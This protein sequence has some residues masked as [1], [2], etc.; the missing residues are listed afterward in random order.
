LELAEGLFEPSARNVVAEEP[1]QP[2]ISGQGTTCQPAF[3][4]LSYVWGDPG[5]TVPIGVDGCELFV[6][7]NLESF[8]RRLRSVDETRILWADAICIDQ[9]N[10]AERSSQVNLMADIYRS[11][12]KVLIW[13]GE[14]D[15]HTEIAFATVKRLA[16]WRVLQDEETLAELVA[17]DENFARPDIIA[18]LKCEFTDLTME[19]VISMEST[20]YE[21]SWW[22]RIWTVQEAVIP[23][24]ATII[25]GSFIIPWS[26]GYHL[27]LSFIER[28]GR[29]MTSP[30]SKLAVAQLAQ[31]ALTLWTTLQGMKSLEDDRRGIHQVLHM[32]TGSALHP[33]R[34]TDPRDLLYGILSLVDMKTLRITPDYSKSIGVVFTELTRALIRDTQVLSTICVRALPEWKGKRAPFSWLGQEEAIPS[35]VPDYCCIRY[36]SIVKDAPRDYPTSEIFKADGRR[37]INV[38]VTLGE[39]GNILQLQRIRWDV[40][41]YALRMYPADGSNST[42]ET[43]SAIAQ[44]WKKML[45][46][47]IYPT[48]EDMAAVFYR[49]L[50]R[51]IQLHNGKME[52][53]D[54]SITAKHKR[55][56]KEWYNESPPS[57]ERYRIKLDEASRRRVYSE[58]E[59]SDDLEEGFKQSMLDVFIEEGATFILTKKGYIG[60]VDGVAKTED[61]VC[62]AYGSCVPLILRPA[63]QNFQGKFAPIF[64]S[65][66]HTLVGAAY[67]HGIMDGEVTQS[68]TA[69]DGE[70]CF[71]I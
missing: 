12:K 56:F 1:G 35:W 69:S 70:S 13:L 22:S 6:T 3:E 4:A 48:G 47:L 52:R 2:I 46:G 39:S 63:G 37:R 10:L 55:G 9:T 11:A 24:E 27:L 16:T 33:R 44:E 18:G 21:R 51:D 53:L 34:C 50:R 54:E 20:F 65:G 7:T 49:T 61:E 66:F 17:E 67:I 42:M 28:R 40:V 25:C 5:V 57:I 45:Q 26:I 64:E 15:E 71:L 31:N 8:L 59:D 60:I 19:Q 41:S 36:S 68:T 29:D 23:R 14:E 32:I 62:I 43:R 58:D 30:P 38:N